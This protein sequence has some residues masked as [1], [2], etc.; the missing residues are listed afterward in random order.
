MDFH[1]LIINRRSIRK[2]TED[3]I[4]SDDVKLILEAALLSPT[5]K[6]ARAWQLVAIEDKQTL[7]QLAACKPAGAVSIPR[8][9][10][11]IAVA[12]D[13]TK[14]EAWIED[15][16][17]AASFMQL[18][19]AALGL[20]SCWVQLYGRFTADGT[21]SD[22]FVQETLGIPEECSVLC[23]LTFGHPDEIRKPQDTD[24]LKWENVH[25]GK[26]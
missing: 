21:P 20:G 25:I 17:V 22:Q 7:Q 5:S 13:S 3:P 9:S 24:K 1:E 19:A 26:W 15:A 14:S 10:L 16:S 18:Q 6:S 2:Y 11:A 12:V 23:I 4:S 8:C